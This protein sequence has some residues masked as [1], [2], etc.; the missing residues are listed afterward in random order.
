VRVCMMLNPPFRR[1]ICGIT[2]VERHLNIK[3]VKVRNL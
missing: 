2:P 1:G 3:E